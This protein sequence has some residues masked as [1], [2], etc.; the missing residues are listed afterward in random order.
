MTCRELADFIDDYREGVLEAE[1]RA[2]FDRHLSR[3]PNCVRYLAA[4]EKTITLGRQAFATEDADVRPAA[5]GGAP[6]DLI[7]AI[8][9]ARPSAT[10]PS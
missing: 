9:A 7:R 2:R 8:M 5:A 1:V 3:C 4:Y 6:E 10:N